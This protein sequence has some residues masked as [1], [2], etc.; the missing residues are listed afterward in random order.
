M[1]KNSVPLLWRKPEYPGGYPWLFSYSVFPNLSVNLSALLI[2]KKMTIKKFHVL[3]NYSVVAAMLL[4]LVMLTPIQS[5]RAAKDPQPEALAG[6]SLVVNAAAS[7][8]AINPDVYGLNF[9]KES[10]AKEIALPARRWG[11]NG[12]SRYNWQNGNTNTALDWYFENV[13]QYNPLTN[14]KETHLQWIDQNK[15]TG[16][17]S[18][19]TVPMLGYVAKDSTS[20]GYS[21]ARYGSQ[22]DS[23]SSW[24]PDCGNGVKSNSSLI[25]NN[26]PTDTSLAVNETFVNNWVKSLVT[27]YGLAAAGG[28]RYYALDNEPDLWG[29]THRDVHPNPQSYAELL[30]KTLAYSAA[31]KSAD[32]GAKVFGYCSY[33]WTG[34][35]YSEL[36][37]LTA[38]KNGYTYFPDYQTHGN[39]YQTQWYLQ[40][41]RQ[42]DLASGTRSLDYLDLHF[43]SD[44]GVSLATAGDAARQALRLRSTRSLWDPT[45]IEESWIGG[46]EQPLDWRTVRLIP[47][48]RNWVSAYYPGTRL[49]I[50]EYN[51]GG[52]ESING[53]LAQ[54]DTLGIFGRE[55]LDFASLWNYPNSGDG[56]GYDHFESL[57]GAYAFRMFRNYDGKGGQFGGTSVSAS[58]SNQVSLALH[59]ARRSSDSAL[60]VMVINKSASALSSPLSLLNFQNVGLAHVFNYS[61]ANLTAILAKPDLTFSANVLTS[62]YPANSITL[63]VIPPAPTTITISGKAG[64]AGASLGYLDGIQKT[65]VAD[66]NGNYS[67]KVP[68][69]WSG[70]VKPVKSGV[71]YFTPSTKTYTSL[72]TNQAAQNYRANYALNFYSQ[73]AYDGYVREIRA[74]SG[75]GGGLNAS[76]TTF[77]VGDDALNR[78]FRGLL[79]FDTANLPNTA[80]VVSAKV[81]LKLKSSTPVSPLGSLG[82]LVIEIKNGY[83]GVSPSLGLD[84]FKALAALK[85]AGTVAKVPVAG[86]YSGS[87]VAG[88]LAYVNRAGLTQLRLCFGLP[89]NNN[90]L[91]NYLNFYSAN[92]LTS[93]NRP[94]LQVVYYLP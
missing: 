77:A 67:I 27:H 85:A 66:A 78:Q 19:L 28:V 1:K 48:M 18:L 80:V 47:R 71:A 30:S 25:T 13:A 53:A 81:R 35:W 79:S 8:H 14:A 59:A 55:G 10:F 70:S 89:T 50:T 63:L 33:G 93:A 5:A 34:Y 38:A 7:Q 64:V 82:D 87:L 15:R 43:Y 56:L 40:Q 11:G 61:S 42:H 52:L 41:L 76:S 57:P 62:T 69:N 3:F 17:R 39:T 88:A 84:D 49:A 83:F 4:Q 24:R 23:D 46:S 16:S 94:L 12:T 22:Q 73:A 72:K 44:N 2:G 9:A 60:T 29:D 75:I 31:I 6:P 91:A 45:Y 32:P 86:F 90:A 68:I 36:D 92:E 21:I 37:A 65:V 51:F 54:A 58:S 20:C 26:N 74:A